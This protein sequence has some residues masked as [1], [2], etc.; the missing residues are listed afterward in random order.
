MIVADYVRQSDDHHNIVNYNQHL[1]TDCTKY[2][3]FNFVSIE[4]G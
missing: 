1:L 2:S 3:A 4:I